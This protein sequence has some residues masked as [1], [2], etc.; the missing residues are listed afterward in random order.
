MR[1]KSNKL[2]V[3][4][5]ATATMLPWTANTAQAQ[6]SAETAN[7]AS[8]SG[9]IVV[10]A[11]RTEQRLD[12]VPISI[13]AYTQKQMDAQSVRSIADIT[14]LTPGLTFSRVTAAMGNN[15][16]INIRGIA[17]TFGASTTGIY[18]NDTPIQVR[19]VG[20]LA[21][22]VY[23]QVFDLERV[24]VLRGPQG[25]LF[26][27]SSEGGNVRF[28]TP[29]PSMTKSSGYGRQEVG[30]TQ[31]GAPSYE[32]GFAFGAPIIEGKLGFRVSGWYR[33]DGG[34]I[35][36]IP[37]DG[38]SATDKNANN[39]DSYVLRAAV[40]WS[41]VE[42]LKITPSVSYQKI[43]TNDVTQFWESKS[44]RGDRR[45]VNGNN[46]SSP[47]RDRFVLP[48]LS[49]EY[50]L[51]TVV[52]NSETSY[53]DRK[54]VFDYDY[55]GYIG[56]VFG[57]TPYP[58]RGVPGFGVVAHAV[59]KQKNFTQEV[60]LSSG[61]AN[62]PL[63]WVIGGFYTHMKQTSL[64][65]D[66]DPDL[67]AM[68]AYYRGGRTISQ[69][70]GPNT[71]ASSP[72]DA[73][74]RNSGVDEQLAGFGQVDFK[75]TDKLTL[76]AGIRVSQTKFR[77]VAS[78]SGAATAYA[79]FSANTTETPVTP[80]FGIAYQ[81]TPETMVYASAAKGFRIGGVNVPVNTTSCATDL[82][83][84]GLNQVPGSYKSDSVWSYEAGLKT[85]LA[86]GKV[87][88]SGSVFRVDWS[89]IQRVLRLLSCGTGYYANA[90]DARSQ[91]FDLS[92]QVR[93]I[94]GLM[95]SSTVGYTDAKYLDPLLAP[96]GAVIGAKN[97]AVG[98]PKWNVVVSGEYT[99]K[100]FDNKEL[101]LR[102][103]YQYT[104][105]MPRTPELNPAAT[106]SY[107]AALYALPAVE[108]VNIRTGVRFDGVDVSI[109]VNNLFDASPVTGRYHA[110][111]ASS[112]FL[113]STLRPRTIG[114]TATERF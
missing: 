18:I 80:K 17:S 43:D 77:A 55:T 33:R 64:Q 106:V 114:I 84:L 5:L 11:Q 98:S 83:A 87:Q 24:E 27:A 108:S 74:L 22:N 104:S 85:R 94:E 93:P 82:T 39:Q 51:G 53:F 13:S 100:G 30:F 47:G 14:R 57:G 112:L 15:T 92:A 3:L 9:D 28:I 73:I 56:A 31:G 67:A 1:D 89:N 60:R 91:G 78:Q 63:H 6:E 12:K 44:D 70:F 48:S 41:P 72:Y 99:Y 107:D 71:D 69:V 68:I 97:D 110:T 25:T 111:R 105:K 7:A 19:T 42:D 52:F 102:G 10:T 26:G 20:N 90:G 8:D 54:S 38:T 45:F 103:D 109:F 50:D 86:G 65:A 40:S 2:R 16:Q 61:D 46:L 35:D 101:Y 62:S 23:P 59:N 96:S 32:A 88:L 75:P 36:R 79:N 49:V 21:N 34:W 4:L 113:D 66:Y 58:Y 95:L 81:A 37:D 29:A 76:T